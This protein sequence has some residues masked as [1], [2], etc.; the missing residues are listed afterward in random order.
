MS[1]AELTVQ[2][3][4][5]YTLVVG[6]ANAVAAVVGTIVVIG[7][8]V[9]TLGCGCVLVVFPILHLAACVIDFMAYARLNE[10]P[11]PAVYAFVK[12]SAVMDLVS[13]FA[14]VPLIFGIMK[15]QL[16]GT[17]EVRRHFHAEARPATISNTKV[18][19]D[20]STAQESATSPTTDT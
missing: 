1:Q 16:L 15:L 10:T 4:R 6:I 11:T 13:G 5:T 14:I 8:G 17:E 19:S 18:P 3:I 7:V 12:T 2:N 20:D 9:S